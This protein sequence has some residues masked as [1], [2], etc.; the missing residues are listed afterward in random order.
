[1][2]RLRGHVTTGFGVAGGNLQHL[3]GLIAHR[4]GLPQIVT[5]T[6]NVRL[7]ESYFVKPDHALSAHEYNGHEVI[8]LQRAVISGIAALI[9][10]P[11]THELD[12][13]FG[14]GTT[15]L[16]LLA[17][18]HLRNRL[19]LQNGSEVEVELEGDDAWWN[20]ARSAI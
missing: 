7:S 1:M 5:G 18:V 9:M 19:E 6:L 20:S 16:E 10:R 11:H 2:I 4:S 17:P 14:H 15:T 8:L 12:E 13:G 3:E